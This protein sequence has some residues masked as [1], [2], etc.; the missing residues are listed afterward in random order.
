MKHLFPLALCTIAMLAPLQAQVSRPKTFCNPLD[1]PYRF[2][3]GGE[4]P[5]REAADPTIV[6]HKGEFWL[7]ALE[8]RW[9][10]ALEGLAEMGLHRA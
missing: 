7:F 3:L 2:G 1:L 6:T 9:L 5:Y 10:L 8:E 4:N